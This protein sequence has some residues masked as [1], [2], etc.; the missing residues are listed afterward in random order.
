MVKQK[1]STNMSTN[2]RAFSILEENSERGWLKTINKLGKS[3]NKGETEY[4]QIW[5]RHDKMAVNAQHHQPSPFHAGQPFPA[6]SAPLGKVSRREI[7]W[8]SRETRYHGDFYG[9]EHCLHARLNAP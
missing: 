5:K 7:T 8:T 2:I 6:G 4:K 9:R 3:E 1:I